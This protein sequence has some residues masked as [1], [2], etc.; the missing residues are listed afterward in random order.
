MNVITSKKDLLRVLTR[1]QAVAD[2]RSTMPVL[3]NVLLEAGDDGLRL[4]AT[5]LYL[6]VSGTVPAEVKEP[7]SIAVPARDLFDRVRMMPDGQVGIATKDNLATTL[8]AVGAARR[9]TLRGIPGSEFPSLPQSDDDA[10]SIVLDA[11]T[12]S[13]LIAST[14]CSISEDVSRLHLNSALFECGEDRVRM[15]TTDGHRLSKREFVVTGEHANTTMLIPLKGVTELK[16]LCDEAL[17]KSNK[18]EEGECPQ[19]E[20]TQVGPFAFFQ[21]A[22]FQFSVKLVDGQ[23]PPFEQIVPETSERTVRVS[24]QLLADA[25]RAVSLAT[26]DRTGGVK[27]TLTPGKV[28]LESESPESGEGFDEVPVEYDGAEI[29]LG[30]CAGYLLDVLGAIDSDEVVLGVGAELD[31]AVIKPATDGDGSSYLAVVMP[32]RV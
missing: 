13:D 5:D 9:Y 20:L 17:A 2:K 19:L 27:V 14:Q 8:R 16:R 31:P 11:Q 30:F 3:G 32:M 26:S 6:A 12:L 10:Q 22:G 28:R 21:L 4:A 15:V 23:F 24:R 18:A 7:G 1:C 25:L 29:T